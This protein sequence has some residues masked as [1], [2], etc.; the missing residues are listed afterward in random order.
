[1]ILVYI[2]NVLFLFLGVFLNSLVIL[3]FWRSTQLRKKLCYFMIMV[4]SGFDLLAAK[5][6]HSLSVLMALLWLTGKLGIYARWVHTSGLLT[7][8]LLSMS[9]LALLAM[10]FDRYLAISHPLFHRT[11]VTER[12]L[13]ILLAVVNILQISLLLLAE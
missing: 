3:T 7:N 10:N 2:L 13:L 12:K 6:N 5:V 4:L 8:I 1:M 11:S 9:L